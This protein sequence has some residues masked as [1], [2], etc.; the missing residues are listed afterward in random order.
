MEGVNCTTWSMGM[1]TPFR[2]MTMDLPRI[3]TQKEEGREGER[4]GERK[5]EGKENVQVHGRKTHPR[6]PCSKRTIS[7]ESKMVGED[8]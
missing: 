2:P 7:L 4:E 3:S 1:I 5:G 6:G 8:M